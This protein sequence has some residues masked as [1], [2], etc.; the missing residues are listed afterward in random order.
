MRRAYPATSAHKIAASRRLTC[1]SATNVSSTK[2]IQDLVGAHVALTA[3]AIDPDANQNFV[4]NIGRIP[5][6]GPRSAGHSGLDRE[7]CIEH[8][9][10]LDYLLAGETAAG[11][12][13]GDR[14]EVMI[15][16][17]RQA[18]SQHASRDAADV[19]EAVHDVARDEDDAAGTR[20][21]GLIA[22]GHLIEPLDDEQNLFL[23]EMD[24]VGRA[25]AG[26]VP[27]DDNRGGA[28]GGLGREEHLH[29]E[30]ER[31]D[32]QRLFGRNDG[33][34]QWGSRV[35]GCCLQFFTTFYLVRRSWHRRNLSRVPMIC[36][37][38]FYPG[39]KFGEHRPDCYHRDHGFTRAHRT[40]GRGRSAFSRVVPLVAYGLY[41]IDTALHSPSLRQLA[42]DPRSRSVPP[43]QISL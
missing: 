1:A 12:K 2:R 24:M 8:L 26:L 41:A 32:R 39:D 38:P 11:G 28:A 21:G 9:A 5:L 18:P 4:F 7:V 23:F 40:P 37:G 16:P 30:A 19:L 31:L 3:I 33:G 14:F 15:L 25:F 6:E 10:D 42:A 20:L 34:L 35:H 29:V 27:R 43:A 22:D 13:L 17:T 36:L